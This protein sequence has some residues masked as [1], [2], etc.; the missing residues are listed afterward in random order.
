MAMDTVLGGE[1]GP[2]LGVAPCGVLLDLGISSPQFDDAHRYVVVGAIVHRGPWLP[3][4]PLLVAGIA[5]AIEDLGPSK[6]G[7]L[8]SVSTRRRGLRVRVHIIGHARN[9]M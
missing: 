4:T 7:R 5:F 9:N 3:N 6:T 1:G 2:G 8:I